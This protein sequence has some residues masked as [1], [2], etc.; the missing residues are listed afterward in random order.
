MT[1]RCVLGCAA[2]AA[3]ALPS[4]AHAHA[5]IKSYSPKPGSSVARSLAAVSVTFRE[6]V[7]DA[8]LTVR[9][10]GG[11]TVS[12]GDG[13]LGRGKTR[14]RVALHGGL[15]AGTYRATVRYLA[16]DGH[17]QSKYWTFRVR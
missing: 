10:A 17:A 2:A 4:G 14:I 9:S 6:A 5:G 16:G 8:N 11:A 1:I 13:A 12:H 3:L 7:L 15:G